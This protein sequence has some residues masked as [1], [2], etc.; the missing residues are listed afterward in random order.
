VTRGTVAALHRWPVKSLAGEPVTTLDVERRGA[1]GD[2]AHA[3]YDEFKGHPRRLT[4]RQTPRMLLWSAAYGDQPVGFDDPPV[5]TLTAPGGGP[6][7][8][9]DDP[10]LPAALEADL[11]HPVHLRRDPG[12]MQDLRDSLLVTFGASHRAVEAA[13]GS[14]DRAR[15]RTNIH[16]EADA[17]P[18]AETRWEGAELRI[19][20]ARLKLLHPCERCA[21]PTRDPATAAKS[22]ALLRHLH[23]HHDTLFGINARALAPARIAVGDPVALYAA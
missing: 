4:A 1:A 5:P 21:I 13:L 10:A 7:Y 3:L 11:G 9:W 12:L 19:G 15:W 18:F 16:V 8:R 22:P 14:I 17:E 23:D 20:E 6:A 2:R